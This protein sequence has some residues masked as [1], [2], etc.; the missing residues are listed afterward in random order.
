M[1]KKHLWLLS[2]STRLQKVKRQKMEVDLEG[3]KNDFRLLQNEGIFEEISNNQIPDYNP[4]TWSQTLRLQGFRTFLWPNS[5][6]LRK[7]NETGY[8]GG[9]VHTDRWFRT[10]IRLRFPNLE[11]QVHFGGRNNFQGLFSR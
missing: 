10:G 2:V 5:R 11:M 6:F 4:K 1:I 3:R 7:L 8:L 9:K